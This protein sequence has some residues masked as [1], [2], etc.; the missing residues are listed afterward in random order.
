MRIRNLPLRPRAAP[1]VALLA[2]LATAGR[3]DAQEAGI[4]LGTAA[5][6]AA[7]QDLEGSAIQLLSRVPAG[8][9]ALLEFWAVW[10][11][12]CAALQ[13][14]IDRIHAQF[15]DRLTIVAVAVGVAQTLRR[16]NRHLE[17][18]DPGYAFVWDAKGAA[19]RAYEAPTTSF[20]VLI[21]RD[22]KV[23]YTGVG[24]DQELMPIVER[25]V[26]GG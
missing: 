14:E 20:V 25:I 7:V 22:G 21:D 24:G 26:G 9:P 15:G 2:L 6:D 23:A 19:V 12:E 16:V 8:R 5:P 13:P 4:A 10:C 18:H 1:F 11:G 17:S 3:S